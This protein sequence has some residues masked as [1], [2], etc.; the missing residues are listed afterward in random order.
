MWRLCRVI[1]LAKT[2]G[3]IP[4]FWEVC[5]VRV[6]VLLPREIAQPRNIGGGRGG[7]ELTVIGLCSASSPRRQWETW[8][9][10]VGVPA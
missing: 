1:S 2:S 7:I 8:Q 3:V 9:V 10:C 4:F 5:A 6:P